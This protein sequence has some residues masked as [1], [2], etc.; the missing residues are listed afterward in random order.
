MENFV[1]SGGHGSTNLSTLRSK[2]LTH[3]INNDADLSSIVTLLRDLALAV[4]DVWD[5]AADR[6]FDRLYSYDKGK[7]GRLGRQRAKLVVAP[8]RFFAQGTRLAHRFAFRAMTVYRRE[9]AEEIGQ[10]NRSAGGQKPF[11]PGQS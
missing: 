1:A 7:R 3:D 6:I 10:A 5:A 8:L 9:Y 4:A 2:V 11:R